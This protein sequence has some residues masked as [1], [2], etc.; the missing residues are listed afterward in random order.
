MPTRILLK[1]CGF[2]V[3][4]VCV[5]VFYLLPWSFQVRAAPS[6]ARIV[7][8]DSSKI[9]TEDTEL[10]ID[11]SG[12][13]SSRNRELT[14][15]CAAD[16]FY[17]ETL[18]VRAYSRFRPAAIVFNLK[19]IMHELSVSVLNGRSEILIDGS[20]TVNAVPIAAGVPLAVT[21]GAHEITLRRS[22]FA[23]QT[24]PLTI[25]APISLTLR[26]QS[27]SG[28]WVCAAVLPT[29]RS[30][31]QVNF[32]P[33]GRFLIVTLLDDEG[34]DLI[35]LQSSAQ[36]RRV[37]AP[38]SAK[39]GY[40][41]SLICP[42]KNSFW[43]S[44]M[45][46]NMVYEYVLPSA[47]EIQPR[48]LRALN[49]GG[50]WTKVMA[51]DYKYRY[52]AVANW[53]S[54][55]VAILDYESGTLVKNLTGLSV[56][57]GLAFSPDGAFLYIASYEGGIVYKYDAASWKIVGSFKSAGSAMRH[58]VISAD[59]NHAWVSDMATRSVKQ[60]D[61]ASMSLVK[62]FA[63]GSHPNTIAVSKDE[64]RLFVSCRGPNNPQSYLLRSPVDGTVHIF[65]LKTGAVEAVLQGGNQPTGLA[66]SPDGKA[67][68]FTN[69]LDDTVEIYR[70]RTQ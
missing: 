69:F 47:E 56:P 44:Q 52:L 64:S 9:S 20:L 38:A 3:V 18:T 30:P 29:G 43:I 58:I 5:T 59:G 25:T 55:S 34:F 23:D 65:D 39:R 66:L 61:T 51:A 53:V 45:T 32:T 63:V 27:A 28:A 68:A 42:E 14:L 70:L 35:D 4:L 46:T 17:P 67:L 12:R 33:D 22:G 10:E 41:E 36:T 2:A 19:P 49:A 31:K 62:T 40:V 1:F 11:P 15:R 60:I 16:G 7:I 26:H 48:L 50:V 24:L 8:V 37:A 13:F 57:R 6:Q 54:N 21:Q